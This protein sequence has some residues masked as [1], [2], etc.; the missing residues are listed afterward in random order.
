M[1]DKQIPSRTQRVVEAAHDLL[2]DFIGKVDHHVAA[3]YHVRIADHRQLA[4]IV[5]IHVVELHQRLDFGI[6]PVG[7]AVPR[8][9][10]GQDIRTHA[11][12]C[13]PRVFAQPCPLKNLFRN[14]VRHDLHVPAAQRLQPLH[15]LN[16]QRV[17]FLAAG[18]PG[19]PDPQRLGPLARHHFVDHQRQHFIRKTLQLRL[20]PEEAG[21]VGRDQVHETMEL[22]HGQ[23]VLHVIEVVPNGPDL[24]VRHPFGQTVLD[25][26]HLVLGEEYP[27]P[28]VDEVTNEREFLGRHFQFAV[29][30]PLHPVYPYPDCIRPPDLTVA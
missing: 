3:E 18:T 25:Q 26:V 30:L 1:P 9:I 27:A 20:I 28:F 21:F 6:H 11:A 8:E 16:R 12:Q 10:A 5:Q 2:L 29:C 23:I 17:R 7:I 4:R 15:D 13:D 22:V 14:V 19:R 24:Q